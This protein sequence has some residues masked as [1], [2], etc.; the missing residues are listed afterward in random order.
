MG[1]SFTLGSDLDSPWRMV[2][3]VAFTNK[4]SHVEA[5]DRD[6]SA[7][8]IELPI[9]M[10]YNAMENRLRVAAG[11]APAVLVGASVTN[12]GAEDVLSQENF[13]AQVS[14]SGPIHATGS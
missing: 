5:Y 12:Y 11:I 10:S 13:C 9:M 3:E 4:G 14:A 7:S 2:V 1:T 8:Y 6:L